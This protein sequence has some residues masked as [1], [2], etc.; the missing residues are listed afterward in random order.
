VGVFVVAGGS[1]G[2][3]GGDQPGSSAENQ[4]M[5]ASASGRS[6]TA[7]PGA[8]AGRVSGSRFGDIRSS[9]AHAVCR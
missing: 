2:T 3:D 4:A 9:A 1:G 8:I 5:A 6:G 7:T